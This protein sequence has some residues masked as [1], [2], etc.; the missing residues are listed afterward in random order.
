VRA[1]GRTGGR[2]VNACGRLTLRQS[3]ALI[4]LATLL[5]TNDSAPLHLASAMGTR[6][7][8]IF[9]PTIAE[10][11]FGPVGPEDIVMGV[12]Q[13]WCRPCHRH[14]PPACPL[15]HVM[16]HRCMKGLGSD[17]VEAAIEEAGALHR[18]S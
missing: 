1:V 2:A 4:G 10:F 8:A 9:G 11:G 14:G 15:P 6:V 12:S 3:A 13:L 5:V 7:V 18:R 17:Y 16:D